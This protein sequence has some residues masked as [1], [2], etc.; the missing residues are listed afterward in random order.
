MN[1]AEFNKNNMKSVKRIKLNSKRSVLLKKR[2]EM[3]ARNK[4]VKSTNKN[5]KSSRL[6]RKNK[7]LTNLFRTMMTPLLTLLKLKF[8][9]QTLNKNNLKLKLSKFRNQLQP[10]SLKLRSRQQKMMLAPTNVKSGRNVN[11]KI[12]QK[13]VSKC[14]GLRMPRKK[15]NILLLVSLLNKLLRSQSLLRRLIML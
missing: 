2:K 15:M 9:K 4:N 7:K 13:R 12:R 3:N 6:K 11:P 10:M 8:K 1:A 5:K 14:T